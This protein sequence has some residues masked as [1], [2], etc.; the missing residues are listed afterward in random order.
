MHKGERMSEEQR[1]KIRRAM[2]GRRPSAEARAKMAEAKRRFHAQLSADERKAL[3]IRL[4]SG[5][6]K[7]RLA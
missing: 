2:H 1:D 4:R 7:A 5:K 3:G 6:R